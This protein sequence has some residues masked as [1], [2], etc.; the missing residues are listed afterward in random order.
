MPSSARLYQAPRRRWSA[1][2]LAAGTALTLLLTGCGEEVADETPV[3]EDTEVRGDDGA[4]ADATAD[5]PESPESTEPTDDPA[6]PDTAAPTGGAMPGEPGTLVAGDVDLLAV[7]AA[8]DAA[9]QF[10]QLVDQ[11]VTATA[12]PVVDVVT[13][14]GFLV[15]P[16]DAPV[17]VRSSAPGESPVDVDAGD[18][19]TFTG[20]VAPI[21]PGY[22]EQARLAPE[23][24]DQLQQLDYHVQV[25][26]PQDITV[27]P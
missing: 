14:E 4:E 27:N 24:A 3:A 16:S 9:A 22:V 17:F 12:V 10:E 19:V 13:D 26:S 23:V 21:P 1:F 11:Q 5:A 25:P 6:A 2:P 7:A 8:P 18:T 20:T 15:G